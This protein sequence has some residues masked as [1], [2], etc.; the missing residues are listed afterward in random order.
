[1]SR[2]KMGGYKLR[3]GR[4]VQKYLD[5]PGSSSVNSYLMRYL[6]LS[7]SS[8]SSPLKRERER[9]MPFNEKNRHLFFFVHLVL[10]LC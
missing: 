5:A 6:L 2:E 10:L 7:F 9:E 3:V 4:R 8:Q 1:M